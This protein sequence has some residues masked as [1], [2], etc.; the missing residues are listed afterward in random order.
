MLSIAFILISIDPDT[1]DPEEGEVM[2]PVGEILSVGSS[3]SIIIF[4]G[5]SVIWF[6]LLSIICAC[7]V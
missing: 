3:L 5:P 2:V 1:E 7:I 6:E 4:I